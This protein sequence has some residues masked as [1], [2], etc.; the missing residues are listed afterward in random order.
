M[1]LP[2]STLELFPGE[3]ELRRVKGEC[4]GIPG[5]IRAQIPGTYIFTDRRILF[6]GSGLIEALR[7]VFSLSY[8]EIASIEPYTVSLFFPTGIRVRCKGG[9]TYELSVVKRREI[10]AL[11]QQQIKPSPLPPA[12]TG[13]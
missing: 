8:G 1:G 9:G 7:F 10:M 4:L 13:A 11:I 12:D 2:G 5:S 6:R 3:R